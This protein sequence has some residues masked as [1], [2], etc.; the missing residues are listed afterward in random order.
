MSACLSLSACLSTGLSNCLLVCL[1]T[2]LC[3]SVCLSL[4]A[5][6]RPSHQQQTNKQGLHSQSTT[7]T[8]KNTTRRKGSLRAAANTPGTPLLPISSLPSPPLPSLPPPLPP[9][10]LYLPSPSSSLPSPPL[11]IP[12]FLPHPSLLPASLP[13]LVPSNPQPTTHTQLTSLI[14]NTVVCI[15]NYGNYKTP[16]FQPNDK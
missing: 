1:T 10:S 3:L 15:G 12:P 7:E 9:P 16:S 2:A 11:P 13:H 6:V 5:Y 4:S 14:K 8:H